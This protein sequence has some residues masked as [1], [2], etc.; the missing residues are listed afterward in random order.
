M[1]EGEVMRGV[2]EVLESEFTEDIIVEWDSYIE[3]G[4]EVS[5]VTAQILD[6]Y[7][8]MLEEEENVVLYITLAVLQAEQD[9][10]ET[11]IKEEVLEIIG[12]KKLEQFAKEGRDTKKIVQFLKKKC[13]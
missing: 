5:E 7:G 10:I 9:E 4:C 2:L 12:T 11:R 1:K 13:R 6:Q 8:D 3:D